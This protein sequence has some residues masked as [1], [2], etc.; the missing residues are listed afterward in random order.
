[1]ERKLS[2]EF[3][4][5]VVLDNT[6]PDD[7]MIDGMFNALIKEEQEAFLYHKQFKENAIKSMHNIAETSM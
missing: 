1:M 2:K 3:F 7:V 5:L 4:E 6:N